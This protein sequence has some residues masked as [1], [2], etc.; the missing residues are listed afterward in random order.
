MKHNPELPPFEVYWP[1]AN[2]KD[3]MDLAEEIIVAC[4][5][6]FEQGHQLPGTEIDLNPPSAE[7]P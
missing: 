1:Y 4:A 2:Y 5:D 7:P 6:E 3:M